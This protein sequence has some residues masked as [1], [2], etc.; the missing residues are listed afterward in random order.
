MFE[1]LGFGVQGL[2]V[3]MLLRLGVGGERLWLHEMW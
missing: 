3:E 1:S 2:G